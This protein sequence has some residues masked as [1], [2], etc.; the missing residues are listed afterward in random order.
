MGRADDDLMGTV[1]L[2]QMMG[3]LKVLEPVDYI[4]IVHNRIVHKRRRHNHS[5]KIL[6]ILMPKVRVNKY[7]LTNITKYFEISIT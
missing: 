1:Y 7:K 5:E 2:T 3:T 6:P 4:R